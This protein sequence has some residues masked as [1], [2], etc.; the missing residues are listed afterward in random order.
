MIYTVHIHQLHYF[1]S[2]EEEKEIELTSVFNPP[3]QKFVSKYQFVLGI[4]LRLK[5]IARNEDVEP[6]LK[7]VVFHFVICN[8]TS[9]IAPSPNCYRNLA[10]SI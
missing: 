3:S 5:K 2:A 4:L 7:V 8:F 1:S 10:K 9:H 6:W